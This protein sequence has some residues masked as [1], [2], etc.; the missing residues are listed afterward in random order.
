MQECK[1]KRQALE[2]VRR[3][4]YPKNGSDHGLSLEFKTDNQKL[5]FDTIDTHDITFCTGPAG[6]GKTFI[7]M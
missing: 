2:Q 6:T 3:L 7:T 1:N 4:F 5:L